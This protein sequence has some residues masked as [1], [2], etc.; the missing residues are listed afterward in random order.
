MKYP[1]I[2]LFIAVLTT[3]IAFLSSYAMAETTVYSTWKNGKLANTTYVNTVP[4]YEA[5]KDLKGK[6]FQD[7][8]VEGFEAYENNAH[9]HAWRLFSYASK[10]RPGN[11]ESNV[12]HAKSEYQHLLHRDGE[13]RAKKEALITVNNYLRDKPKNYVLESLKRRIERGLNPDSFSMEAMQFVL[14]ARKAYGKK[15]YKTSSALYAKSVEIDPHNAV[16]WDSYA[17]AFYRSLTGSKE[18]RRRATLPILEKGYSF[19]PDHDKL[20]RNIDRTK[21]RLSTK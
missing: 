2:L 6:S 17:A 19:N 5:D 4:T 13:S 8:M 16:A 15:D 14:D 11:V 10:Q 3:E 9:K 7:L 20:K 12:W 1:R 21:T 18:E